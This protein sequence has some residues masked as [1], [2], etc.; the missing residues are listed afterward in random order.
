MGPLSIK[1]HNHKIWSLRWSVKLIYRMLFKKTDL[2]Q[3]CH[4]VD[5]ENEAPWREKTTQ[6]FTIGN[7]IRSLTS[8]TQ[9]SQDQFFFTV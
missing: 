2:M 7:R 9:H 4:F 3:V 1:M 8:S 6:L 5:G